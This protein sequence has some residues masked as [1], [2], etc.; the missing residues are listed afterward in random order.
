[1]EDLF[2]RVEYRSEEYYTA[3]ARLAAITSEFAFFLD[4][5]L[6]TAL[7]RECA[8]VLLCEWCLHYNMYSQ[9]VLAQDLY[10]T[11]YIW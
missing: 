8:K 4:M 1:M 5:G 2:V 11:D 6:G 3:H 10:T 7:M 9:L